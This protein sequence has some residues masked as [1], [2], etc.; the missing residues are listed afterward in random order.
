MTGQRHGR[1]VI[2]KGLAYLGEVWR[3]APQVRN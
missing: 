2:A 3:M 1:Y